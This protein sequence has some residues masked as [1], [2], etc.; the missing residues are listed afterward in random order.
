[1]PSVL[2]S[3]SFFLPKFNLDSDWLLQDPIR[4]LYLDGVKEAGAIFVQAL[5]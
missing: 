2:E 3:F 5:P 4:L 1:M